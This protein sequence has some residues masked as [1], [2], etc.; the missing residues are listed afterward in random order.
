M[1]V[2]LGPPQRLPRAGEYALGTDGVPGVREG[3]EDVLDLE[4]VVA[5]AAEPLAVTEDTSEL[6]AQKRVGWVWNDIQGD[7]IRGFGFLHEGHYF[8][9]PPWKDHITWLRR[10][11]LPDGGRG[12]WT[13]PDGRTIWKA[14]CCDSSLRKA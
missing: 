12:R 10:G 6:R 4:D 5:G 14:S 1:R 8:V 2:E 13:A 11:T 3:G 9:P 7:Q